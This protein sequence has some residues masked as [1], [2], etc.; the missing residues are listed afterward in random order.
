[1]SAEVNPDMATALLES[2]PI[3]SNQKCAFCAPQLRT[4]EYPNSTISA[5]IACQMLR[6]A[7][8]SAS[9]PGGHEG[10]GAADR[11]PGPPAWRRG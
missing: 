2:A 4:V 1:M 7:N 10:T 5:D 9:R 3:A 6:N 11:R 8:Y